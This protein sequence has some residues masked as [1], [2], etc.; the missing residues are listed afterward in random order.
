M[1]YSSGVCQSEIQGLKRKYNAGNS[2]N[3]IYLS[4]VGDVGLNYTGGDRCHNNQYQRSTIITFVCSPDNGLGKPV[5]L[6]ELEDCT[7][8]ISWHTNLVCEH[9]VNMNVYFLFINP[10]TSFVFLKWRNCK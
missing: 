2:V 10:F 9:E 7:Y 5:Y 1:F 3:D 6:D 4:D 8:Y